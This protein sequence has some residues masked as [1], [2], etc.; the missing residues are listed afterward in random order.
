MPYHG[1]QF[2]LPFFVVGSADHL[3]GAAG[4][5]WTVNSD[6]SLS[7]N[8]AAFAPAVNAPTALQSGWYAL[9]VT[10]AEAQADFLGVSIVPSGTRY[11]PQN[12]LIRM[13]PA[14]QSFYAWP[15]SLYQG[16]PFRSLAG[17]VGVA[18]NKSAVSSGAYQVIWYKADDATEWGQMTITQSAGFNP[19]TALDTV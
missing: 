19:I 7:K 17:A 2:T 18:T 9:T 14:P 13:D 6:A 8:G 1:M 11:D 3:T 10:S 5:T 16:A 12:L 15:Q 4:I